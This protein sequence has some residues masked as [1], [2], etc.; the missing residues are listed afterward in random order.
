MHHAIE[1]QDW[2]L[3]HGSWERVVKEHLDELKA[4]HLRH[5]PGRELHDL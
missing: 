3:C 4:R 2:L 1:Q 5:L